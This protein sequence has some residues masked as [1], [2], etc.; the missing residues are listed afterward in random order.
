MDSIE[1]C[2]AFRNTGKCRYNE[3]CKF[4]H[5]DGDFIEPPPRGMC[6]NFEQ[7]VSFAPTAVYRTNVW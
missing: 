2:R 7:N 4:E 1:I 6:F 3:E 5:S